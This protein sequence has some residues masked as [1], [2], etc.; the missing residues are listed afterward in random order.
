ML[1]SIKSDLPC[2]Q[3]PLIWHPSDRRRK[4]ACAAICEST[5]LRC[6]NEG[7]VVVKSSVALL[8][9][10]LRVCCGGGFCTLH[11]AAA[12]RQ[13]ARVLNC[14]GPMMIQQ[15]VRQLLKR[16]LVQFEATEFA[17]DMGKAFDER[18]RSQVHEVL[19]QLKQNALYSPGSTL[20]SFNRLLVQALLGY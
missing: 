18:C 6:H 10:D 14:L 17:L 5:G 20:R 3:H 15:I 4:T 12:E 11:A 19:M 16:T 9:V 8:N 7:T 13:R 1:N 2:D